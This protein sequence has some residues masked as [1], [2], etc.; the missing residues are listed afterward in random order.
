MSRRIALVL[1]GGG[2]K[3]FAH[4]G[5]LRALEE[6]RIVP[7]VFAG[8]SIGAM[9]GAAY[10]GGATVDDMTT[11]V[12][13]MRRKD[14]F[15]VN[16]FGMLLDRMRAPSIYLEEPLRELCDSSIPEGNFAAL[17]K[18]LLVN[19][20]DIDRGARVVW[21][22][23][24]LEDVSVRDAVYASCAL[25]GFFPP[26]HVGDRT[27]IDGGVV[28]NLPV[29]ITSHYADMIIAVDVGSSDASQEARADTQGFATLYM[30]AATMMFH[31][32]QQF[33]L[34]RWHGPP[35]VLIRPRVNDANWLS[36]TD[37]EANIN[38]GYRSAK[39]ALERFDSYW[40]NPSCVFPRR[41]VRLAVDDEKCTGCGLCISLAPAVMGMTKNG[42]AYPRTYV[43]EWSPA[44]GGFV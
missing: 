4:V 18:R 1:G 17:P 10:L 9:I 30:R 33:P 15:R 34:E 20:V 19:T 31:A 44:D 6:L 25:P 23:P 42:K 2:L 38:E 29:S 35:M 28:D 22:L 7:D 12:M 21:G 5:V 11:R 32:L 16:H 43:V 13:A 24:G 40:D 8:T 14:L 26:G 36:F 3:G 27:C 39:R 37:T 41:R